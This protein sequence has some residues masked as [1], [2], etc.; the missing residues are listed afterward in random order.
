MNCVEELYL[1]QSKSIVILGTIDDL[2]RVSINLSLFVDTGIDDISK[3]GITS[4]KD[5]KKY[6]Y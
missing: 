3:D 5:S 6:K 2:S 1:K 4:V